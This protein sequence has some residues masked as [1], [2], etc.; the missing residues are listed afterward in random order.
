VVEGK[1]V[2]CDQISGGEEAR[3]SH[4]VG[5]IMNGDDYSDVAFSFPLPVSYLSSSD[6]ADLL[7]YLNS[8]RYWYFFFFCHCIFVKLQKKFKKRLFSYFLDSL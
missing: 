7:K 4:A 3:A 8:T 6:G 2:L 5:S 1:V